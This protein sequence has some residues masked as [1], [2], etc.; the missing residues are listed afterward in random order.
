MNE[1]EIYNHNI[2]ILNRCDP[3]KVKILKVRITKNNSY[4]IIGEN[5]V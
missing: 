1:L 4:D 2:D 5:S 3:L